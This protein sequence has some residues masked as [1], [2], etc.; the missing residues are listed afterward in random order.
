MG[1]IAA[2]ISENQAGKIELVFIA[3]FSVLILIMFNSLISMNGVLLGNDPAVHLEKA[4]I[5]LNTGE[6]SLANLSWTPPLFQIVLAMIISLSGAT[7]ITQYI[8]ILRILT[9]ALNWLLLMSV[10]LLARKFFNRKVAIASVILLL[11]C[12]PIYEANQFGWLHTLFWR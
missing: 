11:M 12:F 6:I 4:Q 1:S 5:F 2:L 9:V 7:E 8:V 3:V 10:Y